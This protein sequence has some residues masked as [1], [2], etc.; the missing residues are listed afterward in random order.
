MRRLIDEVSKHRMILLTIIRT[1]KKLGKSLDI[2]NKN[3]YDFFEDVARLEGKLGISSKSHP[4]PGIT[5]KMLRK[6]TSNPYKA[7][8]IEV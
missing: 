1:K 5:E 3:S 2:S 6:V 7:K 8:I 4:R